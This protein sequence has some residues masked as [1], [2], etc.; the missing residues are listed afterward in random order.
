[1]R[2]ALKTLEGELREAGQKYSGKWTCALTDLRDGEHI[3]IDENDVMPTA[4][5]IKVP[6]LVGLY[7]AVRAG[8]LRLEDRT[9]YED[10]HDCRGSGVLQHLAL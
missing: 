9:T 6:I 8:K 1:M 10:V 5:L 4:S 2:A 7:D 3:A